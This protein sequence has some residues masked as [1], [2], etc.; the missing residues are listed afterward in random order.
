VAAE[1]GGALELVAPASLV[2]GDRAGVEVR[3]HG[4]A[5]GELP[6][7]VTPLSEGT[8]VEVVRGRLLRADAKVTGDDLVWR[9]PIVARTPGTA[10][11]RVRMLSY[12]CQERCKAR[13]QEQAIVVR[14]QRR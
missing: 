6:V 9:V 2:V 13:R 4:L 7:L 10:V 11:F 5:G 14:V 8:P 3:A 12:S 1:P